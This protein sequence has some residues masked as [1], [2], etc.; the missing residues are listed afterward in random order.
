MALAPTGF[1]AAVAEARDQ[2]T[3]VLIEQGL[4]ARRGRQVVF[5]RELLATL[6]A[7]EVETA[8]TRIAADSGRTYERL[9]DGETVQGVYRRRVD[10]VSGR[11]ALIESADDAFSLVPWRREI[12]GALGHEVSGVM[13]ERAVEWTIGRDRGPAIG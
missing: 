6:E 1:G 11:Y 5:A 8:A 13:R 7:R 10:L 2:R 12:A 3:E 4:A 9:G